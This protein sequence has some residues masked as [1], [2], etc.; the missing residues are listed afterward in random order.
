MKRRDFV[1]AAGGV[2]RAV[3]AG[4][5][6][7]AAAGC[8]R[9]AKPTAGAGGAPARG[10]APL[11]PALAVML[12]DL[13]RGDLQVARHG[14][15]A[16]SDPALP[17]CGDQA[18][19]DYERLLAV[20]PAWVL[21]QYGNQPVPARLLELAA[22]EGF[23]VENRRLLTLGDVEE[24]AAWMHGRFGPAGAWAGSALEGRLARAWRRRE[25]LAAAGRVLLLH[26]TSPTITA[27]GPGSYHHQLLERLGATP[28]LER[29]EPFIT[30]DSEDLLRMK[31]DA[32]L[33]V[34]PRGVGSPPFAGD[35]KSQL[36]GVAMLDVP[37]VRRGR[38]AV[39]DDPL[40]LVPGTNLA[41]LADQMATVLEGWVGA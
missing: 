21:L 20:R 41:G 37:A 17:I 19:I 33:L 22:L 38:V 10:V 28:A 2:V 15:D 1:R 24:T 39:L 32:V 29:G 8:G 26:G 11:A 7:L 16:W 6:L 34:R 25:G 14:F 30:L 35:P 18:G 27:L 4:G 5:W 23:A 9:G 12:R 40:G 3:A 36:G 13:G 31:P